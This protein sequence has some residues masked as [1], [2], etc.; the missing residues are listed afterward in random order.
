MSPRQVGFTARPGSS[1][2]ENEPGRARR[3]PHGCRGRLASLRPGT[4]RPA[5]GRPQLSTRP[6]PL[7]RRERTAQGNLPAWE[8]RLSC[9][10]PTTQTPQL[11]S[12]HHRLGV[13]DT[14][15]WVAAWRPFRVFAAPR[16]AG[17][18]RPRSRSPCARRTRNSGHAPRGA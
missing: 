10:L 14:G 12:Q 4:S 1:R 13:L 8:K 16:T 3:Y 9:F 18:W 15:R 17:L 7:A 5:Q 11:T 2:V 6:L